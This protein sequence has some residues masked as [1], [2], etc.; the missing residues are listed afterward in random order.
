MSENFFLENSV[1]ERPRTDTSNA[2]LC[3]PCLD[4]FYLSKIAKINFHVLGKYRRML[5]KILAGFHF[6]IAEIRSFYLKNFLLGVINRSVESFENNGQI[7][8]IKILKK[9]AKILPSFSNVWA[10]CEKNFS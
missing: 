3:E 6:P 9:F 10:T 4:N 2:A 1:G 8:A 5:D 7:P